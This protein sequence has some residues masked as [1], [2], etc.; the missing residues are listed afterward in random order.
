MAVPSETE[1]GAYFCHQIFRKT[2]LFRFQTGLPITNKK[3]KLR[4][5]KLADF[6]EVPSWL[7]DRQR[8]AFKK[9]HIT[10]LLTTTRAWRFEVENIV[11]TMEKNRQKLGSVWG[12]G[13]IV[14]LVLRMFVGFLF[15]NYGLT[16]QQYIKKVGIFVQVVDFAT[17]L[18]RMTG[19][20]LEKCLDDSREAILASRPWSHACCRLRPLLILW[21]ETCLPS[22]WWTDF[23]WW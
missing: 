8:R 10:W 5:T 13:K 21:R 18:Y 9:H 1:I 6:V 20:D 23:I 17:R 22:F 3:F 14:L 11:E 15:S 12:L 7:I 4:T 19:R 16:R 2:H